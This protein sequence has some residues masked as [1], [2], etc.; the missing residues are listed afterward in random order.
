MKAISKNNL[1]KDAPFGVMFHHFHGAN[2]KATGQGSLNSRDFEKILKFLKLNYKINDPNEWINKLKNKQLKNNDICLTFDDALLSQYTIALKVLNKFKL[3][4]FW[5]VYS[6]VF[7]GK[8]D[9]FEI[10]RKFRTMYYKDFNGFYSHFL[11]NSQINKNFKKNLKYQ[12]FFKYMKKF[13]PIYSSEDI[14]F[15]FI[16]DKILNKKEY[17]NILRVMMRS[18]KTNEKKLSLNL[19]LNNN[20][21]VNLKKKGHVIG[22]H[23]Y[24]HPYKL[25]EL[26]YKDQK[27]ELTKNYNHLKKVTE[28]KPISISYPNGSFNKD[29]IRILK[30][31]NISTAF[32]SSMDKFKKFEKEYVLMRLD[33]SIIFKNFLN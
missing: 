13:Y 28:C 3:K 2:T 18:K 30:S 33:H 17:D 9:E 15:R 23:A 10:H 31:L 6:S 24:N 4:A 8:L 1:L 14:E 19:W 25:G 26:N 32:I 5:F 7:N 21:L 20:H 29:T 16:R 27:K 22:M 11:K 12:A